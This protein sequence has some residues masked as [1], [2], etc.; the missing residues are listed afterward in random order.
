M[1]LQSLAQLA[2]REGLIENPDYQI[3][4]VSWVIRLK[5]DGRFIMLQSLLQP[6]EGKKGRDHGRKMTIPRRSGR[7]SGV[8]ADFLVD[9]AQY[10]FGINVDPKKKSNP[11]RLSECCQA[12]AAKVAEAAS[13]TGDSRLEA[14]SRFLAG[15]DVE[16]A[17][18]EVNAQAEAKQLLSNHLIAFAVEGDEAEFV[19]HRAPVEGYWSG[20][21]TERAREEEGVQCLVSGEFGSAIDKHPPIKR[22]PG[23][24]SSGVA[25]V[26]YNSSAFESYGFKRNGNA[27]VSRSSAEAYVTALNRLLDPATPDPKNPGLRLPEQR[28]QLSDDTVAVFWSDKP[29]LVP[30]AI[31]PAIDKA[32][33]AAL[34]VFQIQFDQPGNEEAEDRKAVETPDAEPFGDEIRRPWSGITAEALD[35]DAPFRLLI[36]SG[37]Q[38]RATVRA[39]H[40]SHVRRIVGN[41]RQWFNDIDIVG[42]RGKRSLYF[43]LCSLAL[44]GD[45]KNL[46]PGLAADVFVAILAGRP[47]PASILE[48]A[49]RRCRA[50]RDKRVTTER[51]AIIKVYLNRSREQISAGQGIHFME[52][53]KDMN[54]EER[55]QGYLLG[56]MFACIE[57]MQELALGDVGAGVTDKYFSAACAT[58]QAVF[59]RLLKTEVHHFRKAREGKWGGSAVFTHRMID[60]LATWLVGEKNGMQDREPLEDFLKRTAGRS[61]TGFPPFLPLPEQGLFTLGYHQ[62]RAEFFKKREPVTAATESDSE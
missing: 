26:S 4:E 35:D 61:M 44:R 17:N 48:A 49:I 31:A 19:H 33:P 40:S 12:F 38:G 25:I 56:R 41:I 18:R 7:T 30:G 60:Q 43:I 15:P 6:P 32:E 57:R 34:G 3:G 28:I 36:L 21:R 27:P 11:E 55:N 9:N 13:H 10:V 23:G 39:F 2:E 20:L 50:E 42:W 22:V 37:G 8:D 62:Q 53:T 5:P 29:S 46:P 16:A 24:S 51:A 59:P 54:D 1:I 47:L 45:R 14:V 52:V 58:P